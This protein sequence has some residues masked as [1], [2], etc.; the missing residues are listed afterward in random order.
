VVLVKAVCDL[1]PPN[2]S[3]T[4]FVEVPALADD[5]IAAAKQIPVFLCFWVTIQHFDAPAGRFGGDDGIECAD[6]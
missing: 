4:N 1:L 2:R 5:D 6:S 3:A